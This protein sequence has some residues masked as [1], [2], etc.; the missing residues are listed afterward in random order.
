MGGVP[1]EAGKTK[2]TVQRLKVNRKAFFRMWVMMIQPFLKLRNQEVQV[3]S[4]LLYQR[5]LISK[6]V[7]NQKMIDELTFNLKTRKAIRE[8][9][10]IKMYSFNNLIASLRKKGIIKDD[11]INPKVIPDVDHNTSKFE[12]K[13]SIEIEDT[14]R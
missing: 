10:G 4:E 6:E 11:R 2:T 1:G 14:K 7:K 9:L 13:Y 8:E 5:F 3:L 12:L